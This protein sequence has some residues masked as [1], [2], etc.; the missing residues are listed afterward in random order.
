VAWLAHLNA[1]SPVFRA[2]VDLVTVDA[3]VVGSGGEPVTGLGAGDFRLLVDGQP[4][5][6]ASAQFVSLEYRSDPTVRPAPG[7]F[8]TNEHG[9]Q[10]RLVVVAVDEANI[11]RLEGSAAL[12]AAGRFID[13][14]D[15]RDLVAATGLARTAD[16]QFT[17]DRAALKR[18]IAALVGQRDAGIHHFNIGLAEALEVADGSRGRLAEVVQRECG[19][20]LTEYLSPARAAD[21]TAGPRDACP[22]QVEQEARADAQYARTQARISM[23]ALEGLLAS[24]KDIEGPKTL[25]LLSEGLVAEPRYFDFA[26][27]AAA[28]QAAR[29][30][31][32]VLQMEAPLFEAAQDRVSPS[33]LR[34]IQVRGD[35]L[36]RLAGSSRGALFR[37]VG[38]D[39]APFDRIRRELS[40]YYLLAFEPLPGERDGRVHRISVSLARGGGDLRARQA[41]RIP[42]PLAPARAR[43]VEMVT[44]LR[45]TSPARELPVRVA[46]AT[47]A[48]PGSSALRVVVSAEADADESAGDPVLGFVLVDGKGVIVSS[49]AHP[50][51]GGR[52]AFSAVLPAGEYT[53]R[54][55]AI[56]SLGRRG[57]VVRPFVA[58]VRLHDGVRFSDVI[59]APPAGT[60]GAPLDPV[61][62]S[63]R[64]GAVVVNVEVYTDEAGTLNQTEL[65]FEVVSAPGSGGVLL[66]RPADV[67]RRDARW[68]I[69]RAVFPLEGLPPGPYVARV[70]VAVA[71]GLPAIVER[72]FTLAGQ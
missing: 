46:T 64:A 35:G 51:S 6:V 8:S 67:A 55:A 11:R 7:H 4:R 47:Y 2:S 56:D 19:R 12:S 26:E 9:D 68:A 69:A 70:R 25:V 53:L 16:M 5:P 13:R 50:A 23:S 63:V 49:G 18:R 32:Y 45:Q 39:P 48:E 59:V 14:L 28:A 41:F 52:H 1:Q 71:G 17:R 44:L 61:V 42:S 36:A 43:E 10:G 21:E 15:S 66:S 62:D 27:L 57:L 37:L 20:A 60:A 31:I 30:S 24:L 3:T 38:S 65:L 72:P 58:A 34:D 40:G 22:E 33:L 29:V 54:A